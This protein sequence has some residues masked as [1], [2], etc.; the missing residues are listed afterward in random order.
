MPVFVEVRDKGFASWV[1]CDVSALATGQCPFI[2]TAET[3]WLTG[4]T[5]IGYGD[6]DDNTTL[7]DM[8]NQYSTV[9][10]RNK[11]VMPEPVPDQVLVRVYVDDGAIVWI[12]GT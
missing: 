11:V 10:L 6:S 3:N 7:S 5:P 1:T 2:L 9:Y 4:Q 12:N 8:R